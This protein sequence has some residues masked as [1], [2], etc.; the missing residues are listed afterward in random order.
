MTYRVPFTKQQHTH[1]AAVYS[2]LRTNYRLLRLV[3]APSDREERDLLKHYRD[4]IYAFGIEL[5][6]PL[7]AIRAP[8]LNKLEFAANSTFAEYAI[9]KAEKGLENED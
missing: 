3:Y 8:A 4:A 2:A 1:A 7:H 5:K 6:R 9:L